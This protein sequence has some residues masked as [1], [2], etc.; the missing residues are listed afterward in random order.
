MKYCNQRRKAVAN[1]NLLP[2]SPIW[3]A[4]KRGMDTFNKGSR[5]MVRRDSNLNLWFSNWTSGGPLRHLIQGPILQEVS[6]LE[7]K[8]VKQ[9]LL[10]SQ[11]KALISWFRLV[12]LKVS[13]I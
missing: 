10:L 4:M 3:A 1:A 12:C 5:W 8:D 2:C 9:L 7:V 13:L 6:L 11:A